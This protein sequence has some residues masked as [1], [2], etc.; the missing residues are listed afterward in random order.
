M[1]DAHSISSPATSTDKLSKS[2]GELFQH[3]TLYRFVVGD[4]QYATN[5]R[6]EISFAFNSL[7]IRVKSLRFSLGGCQ[8]N[9]KGDS[10]EVC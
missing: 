9:S 1:A 8:E 10:Q 7:P 5:T 3:L 6:P 4:L 2:G